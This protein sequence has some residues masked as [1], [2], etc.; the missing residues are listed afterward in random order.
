MIIM[1]RFVPED[2]LRAEKDHAITVFLG[3]PQFIIGFP[4][5]LGQA[6]AIL[7]PY[8]MPFAVAPPFR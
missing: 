2:E 1:E 3:V 8:G 7:L 4:R 6:K 5:I